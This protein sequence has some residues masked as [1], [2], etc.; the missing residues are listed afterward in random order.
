MK[1]YSFF[2][3]VVGRFY[4]FF[5]LIVIGLALLS[6]CSNTSDT[7]T[8]STSGSSG[9]VII[10]ITDAEGD[11]LTYTVDVLS[12]TLTKADGTVVET[13][14]LKTRIDFAQY[15]EMTEFITIATIPS[16]VYTSAHMRLDYSNADI[17]VEDAN[18]NAVS[19]VVQDVNGQ[20]IT[21]M[22][23]TVRLDD[24]KSL[25]IAPGIPAILTLDFNLEAS[26]HVDM[27][28]TTPIVT[29]EPF[30]LAEVEPEVPK[31]HQVRGMLKSVSMSDSIFQ[32]I[33]R[34]FYLLAGDFGILT[35]A[36]NDQ[37]TYEI[38][39][40]L[41]QGATGLAQLAS[42]PV[43]TA[44][45]AIGDLDVPNHRFI[46]NEV[47]A[48]S[49]VPYGTSDVVTGNVIA[50]SGDIL[51]VRGATLLRANGTFT[52]HDTV[53]VQI[54]DTTK[55]M[56]QLSQGAVFTKNDVSVGQRITVFGTLQTAS[57]PPVLDATNGLAR[58]LITKITGTVN[59]VSDDQI[60]MNLQTIDARPIKLFD[61]AGTGKTPGEDADPAHYEVATGTLPL[62]GIIPGEPICFRGFVRSFGQAPPDF[63]ALTLINVTNSPADLIVDWFPP[64]STPFTSL[65]PSGI[66]LNM[67]GTGL[68]HHLVRK[69]VIVDLLSYPA[70]PTIEPHDSNKGLFAINYQGTVYLYTQFDAYQQA[71]STH[72]GSGQKAR[73]FSAHG[74]F[75]EDTVTMKARRMLTA[76]K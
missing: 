27:S 71:L 38:D 30:L 69:W 45:L 22:D 40:V 19:A 13:L 65:S 7:N 17:K 43:G 55:V 20:P 75:T 2:K 3:N 74:N 4:T 39:G 6:G 32:I 24:K 5:I 72:L 52:F 67:T 14:P 35:V 64:T 16:G 42:K 1:D 25:V 10:G 44:T 61:F 66:V 9:E 37:T 31:I 70:A 23:L 60:E 34:P 15:T 21:T 28:S 73:L 56:K 18:G 47:Y 50:R 49:S 26:N 36:T 11:F 58:M 59:A 48:G 33:I 12:L 62:S 57:D 29:V 63:N 68:F 46:A 8:V 41:Y 54:S 76:L 53:T 51:T